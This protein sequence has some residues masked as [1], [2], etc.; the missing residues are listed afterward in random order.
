MG[1]RCDSR[2][3][4]HAF[5][6]QLLLPDI[7]LANPL[8]Q[9][10]HGRQL[11]GDITSAAGNLT[12]AHRCADGINNSVPGG[13]VALGTACPAGVTALGDVINISNTATHDYSYNITGTLQKRFSD[14]FEGSL[15]YVYGHAY[16]VYDLTSSV[17]FSNWSFGRSYAGRQDAQELDYSKWD[18]PHRIV[19][20]GTYTCRPRRTCR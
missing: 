14:S 4:V 12:T 3:D 8:G 10:S 2:G 16:D 5:G 1:N 20:S 6:V 13:T 7:G 9:D 15:S 19:A 11:Y 18:S 17:A